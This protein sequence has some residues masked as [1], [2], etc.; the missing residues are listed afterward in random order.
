MKQG[1]GKDIARELYIYEQCTFDEIAARIGRSDKTVREWAKDENWKGQREQILKERYATHEK[2]QSIV[3]KVCDKIS[4][5]YDL[6]QQID[7]VVLNSLTKLVTAMKST[8]DYDSKAKSQKT[9]DTPKDASDGLSDET[10]Q[11]I[12]SQLAIL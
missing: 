7:P 11:K 8:F 4:V 5:S 12:E 3:N 2:I 1:E 10:L 6:E 9:A